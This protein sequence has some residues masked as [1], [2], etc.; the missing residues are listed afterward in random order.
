MG[1]TSSASLGRVT[2]R[3]APP[4]SQHRGHAIQSVPGEVGRQRAERG[5]QLAADE[6]VVA[7][8]TVEAAFN[9]DGRRAGTAACTQCGGLAFGDQAGVVAVADRHRS[10]FDEDMA[11]GLVA[12]D[13]ELGL[14]RLHDGAGPQGYRDPQPSR[15]LPAVHQDRPAL[16][17]DLNS[18]VRRG[19]RLRQP[20]HHVLQIRQFHAA[21][22]V[23]AHQSPG[24]QQGADAATAI[25]LDR[26]AVRQGHAFAEIQVPGGRLRLCRAFNPHDHGPPPA[27]RCITLPDGRA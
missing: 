25:G 10:L 16:Q 22:L 23:H 11:T 6:E 13:N 4:I 17:I 12:R 26:I 24:G 5:K 14:G 18:P 3:S 21:V 7:R 20:L 9:D 2:Q 8:T 19:P 27:R 15:A 1:L